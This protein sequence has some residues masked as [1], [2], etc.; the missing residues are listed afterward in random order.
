MVCFD[1]T[2][3]GILR[4]L[5]LISVALPQI[6]KKNNANDFYVSFFFFFSPHVYD[7]SVDHCATLDLSRLKFA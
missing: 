5:L 6:V 3:I 4:P 2:N 7:L 1:P